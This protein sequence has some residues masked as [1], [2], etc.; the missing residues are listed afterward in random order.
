MGICIGVRYG[1]RLNRPYL[2]GKQGRRRDP[3]YT[4]RIAS[5]DQRFQFLSRRVEC[6]IEHRDCGG[7]RFAP[8]GPEDFRRHESMGDRDNR[9]IL[10][11]RSLDGVDDRGQDF[12]CHRRRGVT[13]GLDPV[14]EMIVERAVGDSG[15]P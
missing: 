13:N 3:E 14:F 2:H 7:E 9:F 12:V 5:V 10:F 4:A 15:E 11:F 1:E 8:R 6:R